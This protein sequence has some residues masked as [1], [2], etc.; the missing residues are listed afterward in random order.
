MG[1]L[2]EIERMVGSGERGFQIAQEGIDCAK[3][4]QF[5]AGWTTAGDKAFVS[6]AR[7]LA[8]NKLVVLRPPGKCCRPPWPA[9]RHVKEVQS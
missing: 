9:R 3:F 7:R 2:G 5:Y 1:V 6:G 8:E 4:L